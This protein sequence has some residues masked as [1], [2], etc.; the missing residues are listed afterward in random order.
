MQLIR[1]YRFNILSLSLRYD[2]ELALLSAKLPQMIGIMD[3][4]IC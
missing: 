1:Y 3:E 2:A 4:I